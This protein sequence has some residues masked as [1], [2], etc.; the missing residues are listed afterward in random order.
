MKELFTK[1][2]FT[3]SPTGINIVKSNAQGSIICNAEF[4][5]SEILDYVYNIADEEG[6]DVPEINI[7]FETADLLKAL[8]H[9]GKKDT[10]LIFLYSEQSNLMINVISGTS[11]LSDKK[12][13]FF[14]PILDTVELYSFDKIEYENDKPNIKIQMVEFSKMCGSL[15]AIKCILLEISV[16]KSGLKCKGL[17][18]NKCV[19]TVTLWGS[20]DSKVSYE[21]NEEGK[22]TLVASK[23]PIATITVGK[24]FIKAFG[25][26]GNLTPLGLLSVKAERGK[27]IQLSCHIGNYGKLTIDL[28]DKEN[29]N[30]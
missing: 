7:T 26:L 27:P 29:T 22:L 6:N 18:V 16:Y 20:E 19:G 11:K 12:S 4:P 5:S 3:I 8:K 1:I 15:G 13:C 28:Y 23:N 24:D 2:P 30:N 17:L 25:K 14:V 10:I 9:G 21:K